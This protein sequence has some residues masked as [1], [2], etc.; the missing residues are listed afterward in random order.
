M[1]FGDHCQ[2][3]PRGED[4]TKQVG[5]RLGLSWICVS[6]PLSLYRIS[7]NLFVGSV[8]FDVDFSQSIH[9]GAVEISCYDVVA[10]LYVLWLI[11]AI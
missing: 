10:R 1:D 4:Q 9:S 6:P 5:F 7:L 8:D 11:S 3:G 2:T